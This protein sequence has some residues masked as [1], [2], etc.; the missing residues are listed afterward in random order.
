MI[1]EAGT[2][3][4]TGAAWGV[5]VKFGYQLGTAR[6]KATSC[7]CCCLPVLGEECPKGES[8]PGQLLMHV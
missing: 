7:C 4:Q 5:Q 8:L 1:Q 3:V 2:S 6:C